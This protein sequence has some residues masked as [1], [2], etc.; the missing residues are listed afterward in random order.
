MNGFRKRK[1]IVRSDL[2]RSDTAGEH[3]LTVGAVLGLSPSMRQ[4]SVFLSTRDVENFVQSFRPLFPGLVWGKWTRK[5]ERRTLAISPNRDRE[6]NSSRD[7]VRA[8][9]FLGFSKPVRQAETTGRP[10]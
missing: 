6:M 7:V 5:N 1:S 3:F 9:F 4:A 2:L 8:R 10:V